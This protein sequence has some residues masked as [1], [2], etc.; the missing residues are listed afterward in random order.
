MSLRACTLIIILPPSNFLQLQRALALGPV[1]DRV[2]DELS[3]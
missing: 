1:A 3:H 2:L